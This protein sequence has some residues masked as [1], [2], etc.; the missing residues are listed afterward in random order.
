VIDTI[1]RLSALLRQTLWQSSLK[2]L[3]RKRASISGEFDSKTVRTPNLIK[4]QKFNHD[5]GFASVFDYR[6]VA[7]VLQ[8]QILLS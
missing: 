3:E 7:L 8:M 4:L 5:L 6:H 2:L 1:N